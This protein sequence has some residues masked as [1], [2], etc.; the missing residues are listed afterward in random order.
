M[1]KH[2]DRNKLGLD[3][4]ASDNYI[5][6]YLE[7]KLDEGSGEEFRPRPFRDPPGDPR[8]NDFDPGNFPDF[9]GQPP[10]T[11]IPDLN[12]DPDSPPISP[13]PDF[14]GGPPEPPTARLKTLKYQRPSPPP[15]QGGFDPVP[16]A[17]QVINPG[18]P[19]FVPSGQVPEF[20]PL[21]VEMGLPNL[22]FTPDRPPGL[23]DEPTWADPGCT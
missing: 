7:T 18:R 19:G 21:P 1:A 12:Y 9:Q 8:T 13:T 20:P 14:P 5:L 11:D 15:F 17:V 23:R 22:A 2:Y 16:D 10:D 6:S 3:P 4:E